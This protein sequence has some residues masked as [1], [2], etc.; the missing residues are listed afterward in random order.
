M[1]AHLRKP[2]ERFP[3]SG[4]TNGGSLDSCHP[5]VAHKLHTEAQSHAHHAGYGRNAGKIRGIA[6]T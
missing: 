3:K 4:K 1:H 6:D 5:V 2:A